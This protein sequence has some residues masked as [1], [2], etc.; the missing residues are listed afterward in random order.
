MRIA[1]I[2]DHLRS[3]GTERQSVFLA[4]HFEAR[5]HAVALFV[6]RK[7][8]EL[9]QQTGDVDVRSLQPFDSGM[10]IWAPGLGKRV[11][12]FAPDI[13]LCMG[14]MANAYAAPLQ[15]ELG[16]TPV[17]GSV[18]TGKPLPWHNRRS[19][20]KVARV[21]VNS[22]WWAEALREM[23]IESAHVIYNA[24]TRDWDGRN[25]AQERAK[26][27][28]QYKVSDKTC[29]FV[30]VAGLR[31]LKRHDWLIE[32]FAEARI[33]ES[34]LWI[35]G[36][37]V[38]MLHSKSLADRFGLGK[39]VKFIGYADDPY[40]WL[41]GGDVAVSA[42]VEDAQPNFLVEAGYCGLP[43]LAVDYRGVGESFEHAS[44][45]LLFNCDDKGGFAQAM[46]T[47]SK[48]RERINTMGLAARDYV[49]EVFDA[50]RNADAYL[51][52]FETVIRD[53]LK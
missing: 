18:R 47:L 6:F 1:I 44:G 52:F 5:G 27:R 46:Q 43:S 20:R 4:K 50:E 41:V 49:C 42:S 31:P 19:L 53:S 32:C 25:A 9:Y 12:D 21:I 51:T 23:G 11:L 38:Q 2:Q 48:D 24:L 22:R 36:D 29:V 40:P 37:G 45:G 39:Q 3:G 33:P 7:G 15:K 28:K 26:V 13:A 8:G 16:A 10:N 14:R 30:N 34:Q 17:I 35:V